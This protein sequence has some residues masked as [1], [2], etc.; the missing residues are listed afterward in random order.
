MS[1]GACI[2]GDQLGARVQNGPE[3]GASEEGTAKSGCPVAVVK[4]HDQVNW[5]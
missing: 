5:G 2:P 1:R 4:L 3:D